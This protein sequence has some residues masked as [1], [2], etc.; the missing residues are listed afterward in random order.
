MTGEKTE[1]KLSLTIKYNPEILNHSATILRDME[2]DF[3]RI[4]RKYGWQPTGSEYYLPNNLR[5]IGFTRTIL[6]D[7]ENIATGEEAK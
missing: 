1:V 2:K 4:A 7:P 3:D 5:D 6:T